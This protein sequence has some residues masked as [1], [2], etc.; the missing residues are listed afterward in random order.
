MKTARRKLQGAAGILLSCILF[1]SC[2]LP[3]YA[4]GNVQQQY[5][6][7][8]VQQ[9]Y[10][11]L[12]AEE[13]QAVAVAEQVS[14]QIVTSGM[15]DAQKVTA[16]HDWLVNWT[17]YDWNN[18]C[19]QHSSAVGPILYHLGICGGYANAFYA[20]ATGQNLTNRVVQGTVNGMAHAWNQ[21]LIGGQWLN[22]DCTL[23]DPT[24]LNGP[25]ECSHAFL[26][27]PDSA[28]SATHTM[29][30]VLSS[31]ESGTAPSSAGSTSGN[32]TSTAAG[33]TASVQTVSATSGDSA[34]G[35]AYYTETPVSQ[36]KYASIN[37]NSYSVTARS[38]STADAGTTNLA[39]YLRDGYLPVYVAQHVSGVDQIKVKTLMIAPIAQS[40]SDP[41]LNASYQELR[42]ACLQAGD[43]DFNLS[44]HSFVAIITMRDVK[45]G[46]TL[47]SSIVGNF[48]YD[49]A[50]NHGM[51]YPPDKMS[52]AAYC[53]YLSLVY[54][55]H[56][57]L[58][59][60]Q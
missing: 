60:Q 40:L 6:Q 19:A 37:L 56:T 24:V 52:V 7:Q 38:S 44:T 18:E 42:S 39:V 14:S 2:S 26:L 55:D 17:R 36:T 4:A 8:Q 29:T 10:Q 30:G 51:F 11:S 28:I 1:L 35:T 25:D 33:G 34:A 20:M 46:S 22:V 12:S 13:K 53:G 48:G 5:T 47:T 59:L 43:S 50:G 41:T 58:L 21:V 45:T 31:Y 57:A 23:D 49:T 15:T 32:S 54:S 9:M 27:V 16:I 3:G